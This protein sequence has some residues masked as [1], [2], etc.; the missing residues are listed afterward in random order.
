MTDDL[1]SIC[2]TRLAILVKEAYAYKE[3]SDRKD[4]EARLRIQRKDRMMYLV[5]QGQ[6][7]TE[8]SIVLLR[9]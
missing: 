6:A 9:L 7:D 8:D 2:L 3:G 4:K 1:L 5:K